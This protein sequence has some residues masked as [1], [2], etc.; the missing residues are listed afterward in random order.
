MDLADPQQWNA[1]AYAY[2]NP[3][4]WSDPTGRIVRHDGDSQGPK[5]PT[6]INPLRRP[7][8]RSRA[9]FI[10]NAALSE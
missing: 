9:N 10:V 2:N 7:A 6:K 1:Y 3:V 8:W 5:W 4:T